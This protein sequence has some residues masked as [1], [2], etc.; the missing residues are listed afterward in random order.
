ML[1]PPKSMISSKGLIACIRAKDPALKENFVYSSGEVPSESL[2]I[3]LSLRM[4]MSLGILGSRTEVRLSQSIMVMARSEY[5]VA[6]NFRLLSSTV[7]AR[8]VS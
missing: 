8:G 6:V 5:E 1:F 4:A 2:L 3:S 7:T